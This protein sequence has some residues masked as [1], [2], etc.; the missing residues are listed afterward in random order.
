MTVALDPKGILSPDDLTFRDVK[1]LITRFKKTSLDEVFEVLGDDDTISLEAVDVLAYIIF[2]GQRKCN[3]L[4]TLD[5]AYDQPISV[6][7]SVMEGLK[8]DAPLPETNG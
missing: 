4:F 5:D 3:E 2:M 8:E 1:D 6:L 7:S